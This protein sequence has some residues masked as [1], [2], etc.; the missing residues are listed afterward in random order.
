MKPK[1]SNFDIVY[2]GT[3]TFEGYSSLANIDKI[4]LKKGYKKADFGQ[5][6]YVTYILEQAQNW[7][8]RKANNNNEYIE[9][10]LKAM[11]L[12]ISTDVETENN[13]VPEEMNLDIDEMLEKPIIFKYRINHSKLSTLKSCIFSEADKK[14]AEFIYNNRQKNNVLTSDFHNMNNKYDYVFGSL[15][16]GKIGKEVAIFGKAFQKNPKNTSISKF[17]KKIMPYKKIND[18]LSFHT[19]KALKCLTFLEVL[20][21]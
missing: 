1:I 11:G 15:A 10:V 14:W 21:L 2:H 7:A 12:R 19:Q 8:E 18:Q 9:K 6:F 13:F 17:H 16:D 4:D 5:G 3:S 20:T